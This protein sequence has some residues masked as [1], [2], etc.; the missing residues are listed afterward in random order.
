MSEL[1]TEKLGSYKEKDLKEESDTLL[2]KEK[3]QLKRLNIIK[4]SIY[5]SFVFFL[6]TMVLSIFWK[7][8]K[9]LENSTIVIGSILTGLIGA[10]IGSS[11]D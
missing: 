11:V 6:I 1:P 4:C 7:N 3:I 2:H 10:V 5:I 8:N 9:V